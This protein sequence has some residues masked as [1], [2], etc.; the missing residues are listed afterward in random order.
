MGT[1]LK[2]PGVQ[3]LVEGLAKAVHG[4][5]DGRA[6]YGSWTQAAASMWKDVIDD[7]VMIKCEEWVLDV[8]RRWPEIAAPPTDPITTGEAQIKHGL[9]DAT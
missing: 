7:F 1:S 9:W 4:R 6:I 8:Q 2:I 3:N 5:A